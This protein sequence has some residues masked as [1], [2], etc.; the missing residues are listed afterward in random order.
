MPLKYSRKLSTDVRQVHTS[1]STYKPVIYSDCQSVLWQGVTLC[2]QADLLLPFRTDPL[3]YNIVE[4]H[5]VLHKFFT[6]FSKRIRADRLWIYYFTAEYKIL[7]F[8][9]EY[10]THDLG[11]PE[12]VCIHLCLW[13]LVGWRSV[14]IFPSYIISQLHFMSVLYYCQC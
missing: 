5:H 14:L 7:I 3:Q 8:T 6:G 12:N 4:H 11:N 13:M 9:L 1:V 2:F 10:Y